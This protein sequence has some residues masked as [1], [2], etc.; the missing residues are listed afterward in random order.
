MG[1]IKH[2]RDD[3]RAGG[4]VP[5]PTMGFRL[6]GIA[7][8]AEFIRLAHAHRSTRATLYFDEQR[9][10]VG[11]RFHSRSNDPDAYA[12]NADGGGAG[13]AGGRLLAARRIYERY[14]WLKA[15]LER[16]LPKR[17]FPVQRA[18]DD[19]LWFVEIT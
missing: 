15:V 3:A 2:E 5:V 7:F 6:S 4:R 9:R 19:D 11:L 13:A 8:N 18:N 12:V 10:R 16:P 1:W 17:R 14:P